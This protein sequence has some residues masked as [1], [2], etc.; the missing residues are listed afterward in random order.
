MMEYIER[1]SIIMKTELNELSHVTD[2]RKEV[3]TAEGEFCEKLE[4]KNRNF[5]TQQ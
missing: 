2:K 4:E 5:L 3:L 1:E